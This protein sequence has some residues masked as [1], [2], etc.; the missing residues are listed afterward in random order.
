MLLF[1]MKIQFGIFSEVAKLNVIVCLYF[2]LT[3]NFASFQLKLLPNYFS[4][5][6]EAMICQYFSK[7][8]TL[9][10]KQFKTCWPW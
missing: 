1:T 6:L 4:V 3:L 5:N 2:F 7:L 10:L 8:S 9:L